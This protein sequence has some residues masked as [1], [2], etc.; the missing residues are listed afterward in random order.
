MLCTGPPPGAPGV[1]PFA[2]SSLDASQIAG[3][4]R[5]APGNDSFAKGNDR[6]DG[7]PMAS[8]G[9]GAPVEGEDGRDKDLKPVRNCRLE[10][11]MHQ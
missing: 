10:G 6:V 1:P 4:G 7:G 2:P 9:K 3:G 11:F 5:D 8:R